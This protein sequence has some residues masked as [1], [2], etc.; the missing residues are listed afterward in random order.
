MD[1]S[2]FFKKISNVKN[3]RLCSRFKRNYYILILNSL[4]TFIISPMKIYEIL[5]DKQL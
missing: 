3:A 5:K 2:N 1:F 4:K